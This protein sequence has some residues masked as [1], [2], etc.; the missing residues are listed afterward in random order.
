MLR[1]A[2]AKAVDFDERDKAGTIRLARSDWRGE[3]LPAHLL[4]RAQC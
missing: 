3:V 1:I 2:G 4:G